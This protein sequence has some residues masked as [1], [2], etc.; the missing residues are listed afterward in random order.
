MTPSPFRCSRG[1]KEKEQL[2][3]NGQPLP[4]RPHLSSAPRGG[5]ATPFCTKPSQQHRSTAAVV[6]DT[7]P[8]KFGR[9]VTQLY[10]KI[11]FQGTKICT[12]LW[13]KLSTF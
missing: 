13:L 12:M 7:C 2:K 10:M 9:V 4:Q 8:F 6:M 1:G 11:M 3:R 5:F